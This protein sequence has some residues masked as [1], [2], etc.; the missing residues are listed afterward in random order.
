[1]KKFI[2]TL[3]AVLATTLAMA[4]TVTVAASG[5]ATPNTMNNVPDGATIQIQAVPQ[6]GQEFVEWND[7]NT[8]A[9]R[10][11][12]VT[13]D[14]NYTAIFRAQHVDDGYVHDTL[15]AQMLGLT[16]SALA[17]KFTGKAG[18]VVA[19]HKAR[20]SGKVKVNSDLTYM[21]VSTAN[22]YNLNVSTLSGG[23]L[24]KLI[25][26]FSSTG[27]R[28]GVSTIHVYTKNTAYSGDSPEVIA[29]EEQVAKK[30]TYSGTSVVEVDMSD[31]NAKAFMLTAGGG[32]CYLDMV[33]VLWDVPTYYTVALHDASVL[34]DEYKEY[35]S[36]KLS[37]KS[38]TKDASVTVTLTADPEACDVDANSVQIVPAT[39]A[40]YYVA[41]TTVATGEWTYKFTM[42]ASNVT[43]NYA[44]VAAPERETNSVT[45]GQDEYT[46]YSGTTTPFT[47]T[48]EQA[49]YD[50]SLVQIT[51]SNPSVATVDKENLTFTAYAQGKTTITIVA[52]QTDAYFEGKTSFVVTVKPRAIA[53][54]AQYGDDFFAPTTTLSNS[55]L[56][57]AQV[58][59]V[60]GHLVSM[61]D[62]ANI[63]WYVC[64]SGKGYT[65][66]N[67]AGKYLSQ[68]AGDLA[69]SS[70]AYIWRR[71]NA[72]SPFNYDGSREIIYNAKTGKFMAYNNQA[73]GAYSTG[74]IENSDEIVLGKLYSR[75]LTNGNYATICMPAAAERS[76]V[77]GATFFNIV[78]KS[79]V[80][81]QVSGLVMEEEK[82]DLVGGHSYIIKA[83]DDNL[84]VLY[85][86]TEAAATDASYGLVGNLS[87]TP[88]AV[89]NGCFGI[90]KNQ[91]RMV[92]GGTATVGQYKAYIDLAGVREFSSLDA[93]APGRIVLTTNQP[94][95]PTELENVLDGALLDWNKPVYNVLGQK[96]GRGATGILLQQ[97]QK[98]L[99]K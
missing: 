17:R 16:Y 79:M 19:S 95:T 69:L 88:L 37:T 97:G 78:G 83:T 30:V 36:A 98:F 84:K 59:P 68:D 44:F 28:A 76:F 42:P 96:V 29:T 31:V 25:Y 2:F 55:A 46:I 56:T 26:H 12:T 27:N 40:S 14:A 49:D 61:V 20:F 67:A 63:T 93:S 65:L 41:P 10:D 86:A 53:L 66:Q 71:D 24:H 5:C 74:A 8:Q 91:L 21:H 35:Y 64:I 38:T 48:L 7:H 51:S 52:P 13:A 23:T 45:P 54:V 77:S 34:D 9:T 92:N 22:N 3:V 85:Y 72:A 82:G 43:V 11:I 57:A 62:P 47:Y 89:P 50:R 87:T 4:H 32:E 73:Q 15:T 90:S 99:V 60:D 75:A 6:A 70:T 39:G 58:Y 80:D 94:N 81:G 1:M 18:S 33:E